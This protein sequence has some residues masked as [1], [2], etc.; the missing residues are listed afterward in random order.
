M[1]VSEYDCLL[2]HPEQFTCAKIKVKVATVA[3]IALW[4]KHSSKGP[5]RKEEMKEAKK[6]LKN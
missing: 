3:I 4:K 5:F 6:E 1:C 2:V